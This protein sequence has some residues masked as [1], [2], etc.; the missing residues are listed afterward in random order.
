MQL[1]SFERLFGE[2]H[3][4]YRYSRAVLHIQVSQRRIQLESRSE[5]RPAH[6]QAPSH[7]RPNEMRRDPI[8]AVP[9]SVLPAVVA[10]EPILNIGELQ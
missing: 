5:S 4:H 7:G 9:A 8:G 2:A 6:Q 3:E 10:A 1:L